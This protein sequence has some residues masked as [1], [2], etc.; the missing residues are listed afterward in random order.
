MKIAICGSLDFIAQMKTAH[1]ELVSLGH[2][3]LMPKTAEMVLSGNLSAE[4]LKN[5]TTDAKKRVEMK[6]GIDA[7]KVHYKKIQGSDAILVVNITKKNI[8]NYIG[9][10]TFL[11]MGFA[12]VLDKKIFLLNPSPDML[13]TDEILAMKPVI[14]NEDYKKIL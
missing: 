10:N 11:E 2:S 12:H 8:E 1:D 3:L 9:G 7:I 5:I 6:A 4:E 14:I 13:Y